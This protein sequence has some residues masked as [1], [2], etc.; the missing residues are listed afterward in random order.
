MSYDF[1]VSYAR[2]DNA[3]GWITRFVEELL[4]EHK[5]FSAG[6]ELKPFFDQHA[7]TTGADWQLYLAHGIAHSRL[8]LAFLSPNYFASEWCRKEWRAWM[9]AEIAQHILTAGVRPIYIVEVPGLTGKD[10]LSD[11]QLAQKLAGL[12]K[13][14]EPDRARL[15]AETPPVVK[16]LRRRQ[17]THNQPFCDVHAF[18]DAGLDALRREDL[19]QVLEQ[20]ARDLDHHAGLLAQA[21]A[22]LSTVPAYNQHFTG[23]LDE[24]LLL[25]ER[26]IKDDRTGVIYGIQG[27]G[28]IGKTEL[29]LTY[30]HAYASAYPGGRFLIRCEGKSVLRDAVLGQSDFTGLFGDQISDEERKLPDAYFAAI[31]RCLRARLD[32]LGHVLLVFDNVSDLAVISHQQTQVLTAL[33]PQLHLLAT[34]RLIPPAAGRGNWLS[35]GQLP[36]D[37]ALDLLE[38]YRPFA[39]AAER[40]A[41]RRIVKRLGGFTLAVELASAHLAEHPDVTCA[42]MADIIG[43][44]DLEN[45]VVVESA[46]RQNIR[47]E[48]DRRLSAVLGPTLAALTPAER[49]A[50]EYAALLPPDHVPLP[51]LKTLVVADFPEIGQPARLTDP[52]NDLWR[53]L[54]KMALF[55][56]PGEETTEPR[57]MR[58]HRLVQE[59]VLRT[60]PNPDVH[61]DRLAS[62]IKARCNELQKIWHLHQWEI[63]PLVAFAQGLLARRAAIAPKFM[64]ALCQ[65]LPEF[66]HGRQSEPILRDTIAQLELKPTEDPLDLST[67]LSNLGWTLQQAG[68]CRE[69]EPYLRRALEID[70]CAQVDEHAVAVRC[71]QLGTCL[72]SLG[73]RLESAS[74]ARGAFEITER[75]LGPDNPQ[76]LVTM[77][78][79]ASQLQ[80][81][82]DHTGAEPLFCRALDGFERV[83]GPD[84]PYTIIAAKFLAGFYGDK[85]DY[86]RAEPLLVRALETNERVLGEEHQDTLFTANNLGL[87]YLDARR[88]A[89]A[90]PLLR[91]SMEGRRAVLGLDHA[92]T[93]NGV[94]SYA[95][96]LMQLERSDEA[97][98]YAQEAL[99][100][101]QR[102]GNTEDPRSGKAYW[103]LGTVVARRGD[104]ATAKQHLEEALRL[105]LNGH[106]EQ[107][108]WIVAVKKEIEG[109]K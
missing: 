103:V 25:R 41:A 73:R 66:D 56:R 97:A 54:E 74:L 35:L 83:L 92:D 46:D 53:R 30:A 43:L 87:L 77:A 71:N 70:E 31:L 44:E 82:G 93:A 6:H 29:A 19:R 76:T 98:A 23:R 61:F 11:Q 80:K 91:R 22:S 33:G 104:P 12:S 10:Q 40:E 21:D 50:M 16:Y 9:D 67:T 26:L 72:E 20:L 109:L 15:I 32:Q 14:P 75:V 90:E 62:Q 34:T 7:I 58:V 37:D 85:G 96:C 65:W 38:K 39:N 69:A 8:F 17:L 68:R 102:S 108:P 60:I 89:D 79:Y 100:I 47:Y 57:L 1:F 18:F 105:L 51:W 3:T 27:L 49:R 4:A 86:A 55:T 45:P 42:R 36:E 81:Q 84:H 101:W 24:L 13:L 95:M 59:L 63:P 48:H 106:G 5:R 28:G 52:W 107:H 88:F 2:S 64:R 78:N 99:D 94:A